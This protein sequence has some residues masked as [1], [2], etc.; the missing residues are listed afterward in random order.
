MIKLVKSINEV[1]A[2]T[3]SKAYYGPHKQVSF[4][5]CFDQ[6]LDNPYLNS[7]YKTSITFT[8]R[9]FLEGRSRLVKDEFHHPIVESLCEDHELRTLLMQC[10]I[11]D[12]IEMKNIFN[13]KELKQYHISASINIKKLSRWAGFFSS[14]PDSVDTLY[15]QHGLQQG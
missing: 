1:N 12:S 8:E 11:F 7:L 2:E 15:F 3:A 13:D 4:K 9:W 10:V 6:R 5:H 14:L